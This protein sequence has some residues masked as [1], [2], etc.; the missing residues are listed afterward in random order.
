VQKTISESID[1]T[2]NAFALDKIDTDPDHAHL[3]LSS[4]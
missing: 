1:G 2:L 4:R 3:E